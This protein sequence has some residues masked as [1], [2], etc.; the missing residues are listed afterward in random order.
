MIE[1]G[2]SKKSFGL[3]KL[4]VHETERK[5]IKRSDLITLVKKTLSFVFTQAIE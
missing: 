3:L 5:R 1:F 4:I 2:A